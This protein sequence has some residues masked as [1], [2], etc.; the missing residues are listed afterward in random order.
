MSKKKIILFGLIFLLSFV[1][2][3][4]SHQIEFFESGVYVS[5]ARSILQ[6][7]DFNLINQY[8]PEPFLTENF[9]YLDDHSPFISI[10][11]VPFLWLFS[12]IS[13]RAEFAPVDWLTLTCVNNLF[14]FLIIKT[15]LREFGRR[16]LYCY[17]SLIMGT[18]AYYFIFQDPSETSLIASFF[19]LNLVTA[20]KRLEEN[21]RINGYLLFLN[22]SLG[23]LVRKYMGLFVLPFLLVLTLRKKKKEFFVVSGAVLFSC[24]MY[25][26]LDFLRHGAWEIAHSVRYISSLMGLHFF[27]RL[28]GIKGFFGQSPVLLLSFLGLCYFIY[29]GK[30]RLVSLYSVLSFLLINYCVS[31]FPVGDNIPARN[32]LVIIPGLFVG[33]EALRE[34]KHLN[35]LVGFT[36]L[37]GFLNHFGS[38]LY[39]GDKRD[40]RVLNLVEKIVDLPQ[41]LYHFEPLYNH[42]RYLLGIDF[43]NSFILVLL[44]SSIVFVFVSLYDF[45]RF[46]LISAT[47]LLVLITS[48]LSMDFYNG[49]R[50]GR[51]LC[52]SQKCINLNRYDSMFFEMK[53]FYDISKNLSES[54]IELDFDKDEFWNEYCESV[55]ESQ[56]FTRKNCFSN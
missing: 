26:G 11:Y 34:K 23:L 24:L 45:K 16:S 4:L 28:F 38:M 52:M 33:L 5:Y 31:V 53:T 13:I 25:L 30:G 36:V 8:E 21:K 20:V 7:A 12:L 39:Y 43:S 32:I 51:S 37:V 41:Y 47:L 56:L 17:F 14:F 18:S 9:Y 42:K 35:W 27:E 2:I 15:I 40:P 55:N 3:F 50:N 46:R 6:D 44:S 1:T 54:G 10:F 29:K 48:S 22:I 19:F 49:Q